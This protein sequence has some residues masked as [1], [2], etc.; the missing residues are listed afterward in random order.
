MYVVR[1]LY[2][3]V[4]VVLCSA[5]NDNYSFT[6]ESNDV[7]DIGKSFVCRLK[8]TQLYAFKSVLSHCMNATK[9]FQLHNNRCGVRFKLAEVPFYRYILS[10]EHL[11]LPSFKS[12]R[13]YI[14]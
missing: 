11:K 5:L 3:V 9:V 2:V 13:L 8:F 10:W 6:A 14:I 4:D 1:L 7:Y 12:S